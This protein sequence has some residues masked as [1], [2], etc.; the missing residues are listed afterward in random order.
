MLYGSGSPRAP[1]KDKTEVEITFING[2]TMRGYFYVSHGQRVA[3]MLNDSRNFI[4]F[5]D[6]GN[7]IRLLSKSNIID[8]K[9][10]KQDASIHKEKHLNDFVA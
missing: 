5:Q 6:I 7:A 9:P 4:P 2:A 3:D 1:Q 8:V 10:T